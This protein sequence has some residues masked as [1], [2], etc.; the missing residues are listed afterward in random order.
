MLPIARLPYLPSNRTARDRNDNPEDALLAGSSREARTS[1]SALH[2]LAEPPCLTR[3]W[4]IV[5]PRISSMICVQLLTCVGMLLIN[6]YDNR[7]RAFIGCRCC[8]IIFWLTEDGKRVPDEV[9]I[10]E[11]SSAAVPDLM[12]NV[13]DLSYVVAYA[14]TL[15]TL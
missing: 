1:E 8:R 14:H 5:A 6:R 4:L 7:E 11:W 15:A 9:L 12:I 3:Y 2:R 10:T 13:N